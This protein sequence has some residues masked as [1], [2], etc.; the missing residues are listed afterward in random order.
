M[1]IVKDYISELQQID[2]YPD[3]YTVVSKEGNLMAVKEN[4]GDRVIK[5]ISFC[6]NDILGLSQSEAV[7]QAAI[8]AIYQY[9][10]S[11][12]GCSLLNGRIELHQDLEQEISLLK[13]LPYTHLFLNA[14]MA[15]KGFMESFCHLAM[16]IP[17]FEYSQETLILTDLHNHGCI[18]A[19]ITDVSGGKISGQI[20]SRSPQVRYLPYRHCDPQSLSDRLKKHAKSSDRI[21]VVSDA[22]FSMEG[23]IAPL[24]EIVKV[25][26]N[27]ENSVLLMDE[28]H[29]SGALGASG[30]GIYEHFNLSPQSLLECGIHP[31]IMTTFSKFAA[32]AGAAISCFTSEMIDLLNVSRPSA[33]TISIP[34]STTAAALESIRQLRQ[35]SQLT[36][37]LTKNS[38]YLR[39]FLKTQGFDTAGETHI[40]PVYLPPSIS[41]KKFAQKLLHEYGFWV[42]PVWY[43][44]KPC[45]RIVANVLHTQVEMDRLVTSMKKVRDELA[46]PDSL[47]ANNFEQYSENIVL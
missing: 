14:W 39:T 45:L 13:N 20:F 11:N 18:T 38:N 15:M 42:S 25:L 46:R 47:I 10:T 2:A 26:E 24:P 29:S 7:K 41:P 36:T 33:G 23:N 21:V 35:N 32:S 9:G 30:G 19:S 22:V 43:V 27:Y 44:S 8:N 5:A 28:A 40:L 34:P 17:G 6:S 1:K 4:N 31:I 37:K 3:R 16:K 12:S